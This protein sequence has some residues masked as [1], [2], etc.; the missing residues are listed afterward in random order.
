MKLIW[1]PLTRDILANLAEEIKKITEM[2]NKN[3]NKIKYKIKAI[4][5]ICNK[6]NRNLK[7]MEKNPKFKRKKMMIMKKILK[8]K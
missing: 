4:I 8:K 6:I 1:T 7:Y 3:N 5:I 2:N